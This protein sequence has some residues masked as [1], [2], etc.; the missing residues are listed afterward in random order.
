[1]ESEIDELAESQDE[2]HHVESILRKPSLVKGKQRVTD[3]PAKASS[4]N[5]LQRYVFRSLLP[6]SHPERILTAAALPV[7]PSQPV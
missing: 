1:M 6:A 3:S 2:E 4:K 7:P 5:N